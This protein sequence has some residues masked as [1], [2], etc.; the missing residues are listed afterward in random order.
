MEQNIH[1]KMAEYAFNQVAAA[2]KD[3]NKKEF[4]SLARSFPSM[5][6]VNGL[7][8]AIAFL[9]SKA[10][11]KNK[12][13]S[14]TSGKSQNGINAHGQMY[15]LLEQWFNTGSWY[16]DKKECGLMERIVKL[17]SGTYRLYANETMNLCLWVKRFAEGMIAEELIVSEMK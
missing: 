3:A 14:H 9:H 8:A 2:A 6:Q 4:R 15:G 13:G 16:S 17:D 7:G 1:N 11:S 5:I 10:R 12:A